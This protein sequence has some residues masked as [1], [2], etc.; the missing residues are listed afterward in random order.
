VKILYDVP[1]IC[2]TMEN[3]SENDLVLP[4][5]LKDPMTESISKDDSTIELYQNTPQLSDFKAYEGPTPGKKFIGG[6]STALQLLDTFCSKK[7]KINEVNQRTAKPTAL[8]SETT[9]LGPYLKFGCMS[10][11]TFYW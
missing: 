4:D 9:L 10:A 6:E 11:R 1:K 3:F 2:N 7:E 5:E 8:K